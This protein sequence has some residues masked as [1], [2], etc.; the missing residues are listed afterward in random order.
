MI[1][2]IMHSH[3]IQPSYFE[4]FFGTQI[5][6]HQHKLM[7][8]ETFL[9]E[10]STDLSLRGTFVQLLYGDTVHGKYHIDLEVIELVRM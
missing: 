1:I 2:Y 8:C 3:K 5:R 10:N 9:L 4:V 6:L 7:I